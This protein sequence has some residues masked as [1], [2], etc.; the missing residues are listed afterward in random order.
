MCVSTCEYFINNVDLIYGVK[1]QVYFR[2][3]V[4]LP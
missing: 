2:L 4:T 3:K 1:N